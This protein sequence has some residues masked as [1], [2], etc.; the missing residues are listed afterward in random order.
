MKVAVPSPSVKSSNAP[1]WLYLASQSPRRRELLDQMG[2]AHRLLL[3]DP[4]EDAEALEGVRGKESPARYVQRV[5]ALKLHAARQR[6]QSRHWEAAPI[7]CA[8]TTVALGSRILGKPQSATEAIQML[9]ALA[10]QRHRVLTAV[11]VHWAGRDAAAL[12]VS[13]VEFEDWSQRE[14]EAYVASGEPMGKA[15]SYAVQG[16]A[17][18]HIARIRGSYSGIMG[19]PVHETWQCLRQIGWKAA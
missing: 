5:T 4:S 7:L 11:A 13:T 9:Q 16:R 2:V 18:R 8:D 10:G 3:A 14:I 1:S 15:G 6:L 12:S 17:A 19:L